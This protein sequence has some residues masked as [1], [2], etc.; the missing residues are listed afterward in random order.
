MG[1]HREKLTMRKWILLVLLLMPTWAFSQTTSVTLQVTDADSQTW[2]SGT[3]TA[4]LQVSPGQ[5]P[6]FIGFHLIPAFGGGLVSP[7]TV[8]GTLG[9][10][11]GA[12]F[13]L[14]SNVNIAP[15]NT[16]WVFTVCPVAPA[17][18]F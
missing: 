7:Q 17:T 9:A 3:Y 6:P 13:S 2:N 8:S 15:A 18:C 10:T 12:A 4:N 11:G 14:T 16:I 1:L 5:L